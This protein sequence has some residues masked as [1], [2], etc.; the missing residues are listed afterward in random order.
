M[1]LVATVANFAV[2]QIVNSA[3]NIL[4]KPNSFSLGN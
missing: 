4:D 1:I 3:D 2:I